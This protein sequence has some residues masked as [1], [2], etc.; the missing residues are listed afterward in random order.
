MTRIRIKRVYEAPAPDDGCRV[1]VDRLW[2]RGV[3][4]DALHCD[5]WA[6]DLAP[7]AGLRSWYHADPGDRWEEFRCR[8]T[9]AGRAGVRPRNRRCGHGDATLRLEKCGGEPCAHPA[10]VFAESCRRGY[11]RVIFAIFASPCPGSGWKTMISAS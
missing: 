2:P 5:V 11:N 6:R 1:L 8:Y 4:R 7:S 3:R 9:D 10:G